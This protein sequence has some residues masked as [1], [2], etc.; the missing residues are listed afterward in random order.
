[1]TGDT[2]L[3]A[4]WPLI[5]AVSTC[6]C[7]LLADTIG[8]PV[9]KCCP[10]PGT[11]LVLDDCCD[12][13]A[14]VR[15][16]RIDPIVAGSTAA[17]TG[18]PTIAT[19]WSGEP[20]GPNMAQVVLGAGVMRCSYSLDEDAT[21]PGCDELTYETMRMTSDID[22]LYTAGL[23]CQSDI[24]VESAQPLTLVPQGPAGGCVGV[25]LQ[26]AYVMDLCPCAQEE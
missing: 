25:E 11:A 1:M 24:E 18:V 7:A 17:Q 16:V 10:V 26:V 12:G 4:Y 22:A 6:L 13:T 5:D 8:G 9:G 2:R 19:G 20:C 14:W 21:A 23:C 15:L 3:P